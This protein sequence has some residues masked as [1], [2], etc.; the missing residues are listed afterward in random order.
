MLFAW[1]LWPKRTLL[2]SSR[3]KQLSHG[4]VEHSEKP[5]PS[6][7]ALAASSSSH[8]AQ[9]Q[10]LL[11][12]SVH[13]TPMLSPSTSVS[14]YPPC[15]CCDFYFIGL[16]LINGLVLLHLYVPEE[17][18][19]LVGCKVEW[20]VATDRTEFWEALEAVGRALGCDKVRCF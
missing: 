7:L 10:E 15:L 5:F 16:R 3:L 20:A 1:I 11:I 9:L 13:S 14:A 4:Y 18:Q 17:L 19:C 8:P 2:T 12:I 6:L